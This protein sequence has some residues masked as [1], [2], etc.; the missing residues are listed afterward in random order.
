ILIQDMSYVRSQWLE[1]FWRTFAMTWIGGFLLILLIGS[2]LRR[3]TTES[4]RY[5][6]QVLRALVAGRRPSTSLTD[7]VSQNPDLGTISNDI[8]KLTA[9]IL[10]L[11]V[12]A[13]PK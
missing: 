6:H 10:T 8:A 5:V 7:Q 3:L 4:F 13:S 12:N 11:P 1:A 2:Q 9:K